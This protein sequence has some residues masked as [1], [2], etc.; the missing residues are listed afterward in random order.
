MPTFHALSA[1]YILAN[2]EYRSW[3]REKD[4]SYETGGFAVL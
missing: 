3:S 4:S 2:I 1:S